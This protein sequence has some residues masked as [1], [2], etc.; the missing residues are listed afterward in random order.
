MKW[1]DGVFESVEEIFY[2]FLFVVDEVFNGI[3]LR[4]GGIGVVGAF[5]PYLEWNVATQEFLL[6][7]VY[8]ILFVRM[9]F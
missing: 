7:F 1:I 6:M 5:I 2:D 4:R 8:S 3:Y 9:K